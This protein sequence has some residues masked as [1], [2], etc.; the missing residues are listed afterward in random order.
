MMSD[1]N[2]YVEKAADALVQLA[3][4]TNESERSRLRRMH[5]AYVRLSKHEAEAA[6]RAAAG[7][8]PRIK[9]EKAAIAVH[10]APQVRYFS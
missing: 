9:S 8:R 5:G 3:E 10:P 6:E 1:T 2:D 4:A 7:P